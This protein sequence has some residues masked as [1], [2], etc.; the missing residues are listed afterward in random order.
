MTEQRNRRAWVSAAV[1]LAIAS[2]ARR[3]QATGLP[4]V[5]MGRWTAMKTVLDQATGVLSQLQAGA[6][7]LK[8]A[9]QRLPRSGSSFDDI[10]LGIRRLTSDVDSIGFRVETVTRQ[11]KRLFPDEAAVHDT[12]PKE[13]NELQE[14]WDQEIHV[15]SLTAARSQT[16]LASI[17]TNTRSA[18]DVLQ[19]SSD[20]KSAVAQLQAMV[21]MI[22]IINSDLANLSATIS[23]TERVNS[24]LAVSEVSSRFAAEERRRR[25]LEA[26]D[27]RHDT[28][29]IDGRFL[30]V[31]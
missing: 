6:D 1:A 11:Y 19:R 17:D 13:I 2:F 12:S 8:D 15:A 28:P 31:P 27:A 22:E 14:S 3:G 20:Q 7:T 25:L 29:G 4:V 21:K 16:T 9:A 18:K 26:Y 24:S 30:K 5:D 10:L 23:A